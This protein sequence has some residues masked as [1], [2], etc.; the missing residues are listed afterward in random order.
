MGSRARV[1]AVFRRTGL[2]LKQDKALPNL[3]SVI[4]GE[5]LSASWW[6]HPRASEIY[7][8]LEQLATRTDVIET[9]LLAG[10][11]TFVLEPLWPALLAVATCREPWQL[12]SLSLTAK[13]LLTRVERARE[14]E[15]SGAVVKELEKRLL[16][17]TIQRHTA[18]GKHVLVLESWARWGER[19]AVKALP[20]SE[21]KATLEQAV[22][23]LGAPL[24]ALPWQARQRAQPAAATMRR[25]TNA[26]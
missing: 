5:S 23:A 1:L 19:S 9:K 4:T 20:V 25:R 13:S 10:K 26:R 16:L 21:A 17:R 14:L 18:S 2:L 6:S 24:A 3:V 12:A 22:T 15:A 11:V 7:S 8:A